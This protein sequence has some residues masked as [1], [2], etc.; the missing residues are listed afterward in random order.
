MMTIFTRFR[1]GATMLLTV[2][3]VGF[4]AL[5]VTLSTAM[6]GIGELNMGFAENQSYETLAIADACAQEAL[7]QLSLDD[8]YTGGT[9]TVG[10]GTCTIT[11]TT[12]GTDRT[13]DVSATIDR[14]TRKY[15]VEVNLQNNRVNLRSWEQNTN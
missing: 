4:V 12:S 3:I 2:L 11:V 9:I 5:L 10:D 13:I 7:L 14:W 8:E 6:R 1:S 15:T